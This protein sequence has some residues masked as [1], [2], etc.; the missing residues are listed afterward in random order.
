[1]EKTKWPRE[2]ERVFSVP[3]LGGMV[4]RG[5][6]RRKRRLF[7]WVSISVHARSYA[8]AVGTL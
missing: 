6:R 4:G 5:R 8:R 3:D 1:V 2:E 7:I